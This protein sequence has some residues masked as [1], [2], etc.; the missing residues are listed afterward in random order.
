[1]DLTARMGQPVYAPADGLV[2]FSAPY[3][4]YGNYVALNHGYGM[5]TRYG[6]LSRMRVKAGDLVRRGQIIAY[7]GNTGRSTGP[8]L[9]YE[10][11][12]NGI[13]VNPYRFMLK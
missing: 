5:V 12:M 1:M 8:H 3:S 13:H 7:V 6:H 2:T 4:T 11:L 10:V 9:H